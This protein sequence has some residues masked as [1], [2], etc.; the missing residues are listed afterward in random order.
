MEDMVSNYKEMPKDIKTFIPNYRYLL[1]DFSKFTDEEIKGQVKSNYNELINNIELSY[2]EGSELIMT[3]AE[4][5]REEVMKKS[6]VKG[7]EE[8][9]SKT[10]I[11]LFNYSRKSHY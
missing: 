5:F 6:I 9:L 8:T 11:K 1:Y 4:K 10:V 3:I 7:K 2:P